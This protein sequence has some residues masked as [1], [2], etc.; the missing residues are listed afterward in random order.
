MNIE[1]IKARLSGLAQQTK[2]RRDIWKPKDK[3]TIRLVPYPHGSDP[4]VELGFHYEIQPG[5]VLCPKQN[6]GNECVICDF[7]EKLRAW[8]D[9]DGNDKPESIRKKDFEFWK[10]ISVKPVWFVA[11]VERDKDGSIMPDFPKFWR[12]S[13]SSYEK[14]LGM[15]VDPKLNKAIAASGGEGTDVLFSPD[16]AFDLEVNFKQGLNKDGKGNMKNFPLTEIDLGDLV[17]SKLHDSKKKVKEILDGVT[18]MKDVYPE[19]SSAE[20][21]KAF[22]K[23]LNSQEEAS[24]KTDGNGVEYKP[25]SAEKPVEGGMSIE[26]AFGELT[27]D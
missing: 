2:K 8:K 11:M 1:E 14:L 15:C 26:E 16:A 6:F 19:V 17:P 22:V 3:H 7:S 18:N 23:F 25:N 9:E 5:G 12:L 27:D 20:V 4:F 10:L 21:K 24:E 13:K